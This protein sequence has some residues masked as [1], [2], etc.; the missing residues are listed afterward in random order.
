MADK[1]LCGDTTETHTPLETVPQK[2]DSG[3]GG[4]I[5]YL[6]G[7]QLGSII[8]AYFTPLCL[9]INSL[10]TLPTKALHLLIPEI[11]IVNTALVGITNELEGFD[12]ISWVTSSYLL[13]YVGTGHHPPKAHTYFV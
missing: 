13:G 2:E 5:Y 9:Q 8:T 11:P 12:K 4:E 7:L 10:L 6:K 3:D 1:S